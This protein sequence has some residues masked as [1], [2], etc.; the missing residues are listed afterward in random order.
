MTV[1]TPVLVLD[2]SRER[3]VAALIRWAHDL[4]G[5][6]HCL[7]RLVLR[8]S[9]E[10][11]VAVLS[12]LADNPDHLGLV[13]DMA[14]VARAFVE[15]M[16][17]YAHLDPATLV[18]IAHHGPF[19]S[20]DNYSAPETFTGVDVSYRGGLFHS[21]LRGQHLLS[22]AQVLAIVNPLHLHPAVEV[23]TELRCVR[24]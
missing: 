3:R 24:I 23:L 18:W 11:P 10:P 13:G 7:A 22:A 1:D 4:G 12:E 16:R 2:A 6:A 20:V 15:R 14:G 9:P 21:D 8:A 19:S 17:P 5:E